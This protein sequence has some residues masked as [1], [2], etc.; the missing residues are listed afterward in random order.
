M[1]AGPILIVD[2]DPAIRGLLA[3]SLVN[4]GL[5]CVQADAPAAAVAL[6]GDWPPSLFLLDVE[7][8]AQSG[9]D[10]CRTLRARPAST[11]TP[12]VM[13]SGHGEERLMLQAFE[14]GA[15]DYIVKPV[16][17]PLF[18]SK[19]RSV[20]RR[21]APK[22]PIPGITELPPGFDFDARYRIQCPIGKGGMGVVYRAR[23]PML[24]TDVAIK[25][26][27]V[28]D[29]LEAETSERRFRRE[30]AALTLVSH[31]NVVRVLDSGSFQ[32]H[33]YYSMELI[34]GEPLSR[35]IDAGPIEWRRALSIAAEV[36]DG[37]QAV[38]DC[39]F[40][41]RDVKPSNIFLEASGRA[42]VGDFGIVLPT[43]RRTERLTETNAV[44]G[45]PHYMAPEQIAG[46]FL[47]ARTDI[48]ALGVTLFEML[49]GRHPY[50]AATASAAMLLALTGEPIPPSR[51]VATLSAAADR[52][53]LKA[54]ARSPR[55]RY[56]SAAEFA[57][58]IREALE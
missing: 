41:H 50:E 20:L 15:D 53:C 12:I 51:I 39:G 40:V 5:A 33:P 49:T 58:A 57:R 3:R 16:S 48:Y 55:R 23:D 14:A 28:T 27:H 17:I 10:L 7:L 43:G 34:E 24:D 42:K 13:I 11:D 31:P 47:D 38:H 25:I 44:V 18:V 9:I 1:T 30:V 19:V 46:R 36:A 21:S 54:Q 22:S 29:P 2:D 35:R 45:S 26:L 56:A 8:G 4:A 32:G 6:A 52:L 37:L